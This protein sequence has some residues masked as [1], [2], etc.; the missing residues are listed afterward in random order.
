MNDSH[1]ALVTLTVTFF[2]AYISLVL[3]RPRWVHVQ[4]EDGSRL[5]AKDKV[6]LYSALFGLL[7]ALASVTLASASRFNREMKMRRMG[8]L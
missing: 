7:G 5:L 6:T 8:M 4:L 3:I 1:I 2:V